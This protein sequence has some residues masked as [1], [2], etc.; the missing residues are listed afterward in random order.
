[1]LRL[2]EVALGHL[3]SPALPPPTQ[4]VGVLVVV[5]HLD[6]GGGTHGLAGEIVLSRPDAA[7]DDERVGATHCKTDSG[8]DA[9][10]V[11]AHNGLVIVVETGVGEPRADRCR[12]RVH[13]LAEEQLGADGECL[14]DHDGEL[15]APMRSVPYPPVI[16]AV[17]HSPGVPRSSTTTPSI[18]GA[19]R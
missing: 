18:S 6:S 7:R 13:D 10:D 19:S 8:C 11:V 9:V 3:T 1:M 17:T 2:A 15:T 4:P 12:I 16:V 14:D 5:G